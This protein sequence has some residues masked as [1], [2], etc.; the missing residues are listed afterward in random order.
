MIFGVG[1]DIEN[2]SR[3]LKYNRLDNKYEFLLSV[4]TKDEQINYKKFNNHLCYA[5]SFSCKEAFFKVFG[6]SW[7]NG[8]MQWSNIELIFNGQPEDLNVEIRFSGYAQSLILKHNLNLPCLF[9][10]SIDDTEVVFEA[11]LTCKTK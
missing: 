9:N 1:I 4:F 11:I 5:V 7:N 8:N 3:F 10:Y 6:E 2:H